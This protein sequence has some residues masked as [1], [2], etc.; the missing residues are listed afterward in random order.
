[1]TLASYS[2]YVSITLHGFTQT[3]INSIKIQ[4][5]CFTQD[6]KSRFGLK[7]K[8]TITSFTFTFFIADNSALLVWRDEMGLL[9]FLSD[10]YFCSSLV[11]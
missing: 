10:K 11:Y 6:V 9:R 4:M 8:N 5:W 7:K 2:Y 1:M 3:K